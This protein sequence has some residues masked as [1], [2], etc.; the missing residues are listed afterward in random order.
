MH[1]RYQWPLMALSE[2][3]MAGGVTEHLLPAR[4]CYPCTDSLGVA[5]VSGFA[6]CSSPQGEGLGWGRA[7]HI[8]LNHLRTLVADSRHEVE[9]VDLV[10]GVHHVHHG[11][12]HYEGA[13]PAHAGTAGERKEA[14]S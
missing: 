13:R 12:D 9:D 5:K 14:E 8:C 4:H 11:I 6:L 1:G 2:D 3:H 10:L 7:T